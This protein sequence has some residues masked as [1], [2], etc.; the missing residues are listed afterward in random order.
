MRTPWGQSQTQHKVAD[1]ITEVTTAGHGG[2]IV[3]EDRQKV[4]QAMFP[5]VVPFAHRGTGFG[6]GQ[7]YYEEDCDWCIPVLVWPEFWTVDVIC[8]ALRTAVLWHKE[9]DQDAY[10]QTEAGKR[11]YALYIENNG[12]PPEA[13]KQEP[14]PV[15]IPSYTDSR[16]LEE[17]YSDADPGL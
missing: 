7:G 4:I 11:V 10:R 12:N 15:S 3:S 9:I 5:K 17:S 6:G 13:P 8:I 1:G 2:T 16:L 14:R